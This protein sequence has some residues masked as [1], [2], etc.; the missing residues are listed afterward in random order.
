[1]STQRD[2]KKRIQNLF[3]R[4]ALKYDRINHIISF[5][6]DKHWRVRALEMTKLS[7]GER[8]LDVAT[9][10]GDIAILA[11]EVIPGINVVGTDLTQEMLD[12]A[13]I[14]AREQPLSWVLGDGT[15]LSFISNSFDAV[16]SAFM[17]RNVPDVAQ[18][19]N[20]QMRVVRP[21]GKVVCLE[22][23]WPQ[24]FPIKWLFKFYFYTLPP[25]LGILISGDREAYTYLPR[26]VEKFLTIAEMAAVMSDIG[27]TQVEYRKLM[28]GTIAIHTGVKPVLV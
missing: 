6:Q 22:M 8:L 23:T 4:I 20:E 1:L 18:A 27:L 2:Q 12:Q 24:R 26:S 21:G 15:A 11:K 3:S 19:L 14:K 16:I 7:P 9:G 5:G 28:L 13:K 10:T 17:M 25:I